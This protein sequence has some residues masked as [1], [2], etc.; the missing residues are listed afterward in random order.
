MSNLSAARLR[1]F[2]PPSHSPR[3]AKPY[4]HMTKAE[5]YARIELL[6]GRITRAR[7]LAANSARDAHNAR[8]LGCRDGFHA[9]GAEL[10]LSVER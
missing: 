6:F 2:G 5:M 4:D 9:I 3:V 10:D 1:L 7:T 8:H